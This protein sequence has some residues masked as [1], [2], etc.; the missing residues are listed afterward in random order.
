MVIIVLRFGIK[1]LVALEYTT[2]LF[3]L[4]E[5]TKLLRSR[6]REGVGRATGVLA[7]VSA[8]FVARVL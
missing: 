3:V 5:N 7:F 6:E 2:S 8:T 4:I 1:V